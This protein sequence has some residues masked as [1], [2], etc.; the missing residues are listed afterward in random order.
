MS[1][2]KRITVDERAWREIQA[3]AARLRDVQRELPSMLEAVRR[4]QQEQASRDGA[5][6]RARQDELTRSLASL[7]DQA[8]RLEASTS[9]RL[10]AATEM[11]LNEVRESAGQVR[12][13]T[14]QLLDQQQRRFTAE[15]AQEREERRQEFGALREQLTELRADRERAAAAAATVVADAQHLRDAIAGTLPHERFAPGRLAALGKRLALAEDN[16][17][18]GHGEAALAQAQDLYLQLGE[19]RVEVELKNAEWL[20]ARLTGISAVTAL[21]EQIRYNTRLDVTDEG[22]TAELDVDFWS[23]GELSAI[24]AEADALAA[25]VNDEAD[26][27]ALDELRAIAEHDVAALNER[28]TETVTTARARQLASQIRVNLAEMVVGVLEQTTGYAWDGEATYAGEDQRGA[29]YSKLRHPDDSEIV[30][31]VAPDD[32]GKSCVLRI[33]SFETGLPDDSER[34]RRAHAIADSLREQGLQTGDPS[35][36]EEF[37]DQKFTD[38]EQLRRIQR[39]V[40]ERG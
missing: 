19:L 9:R 15:L 27:P 35:A 12:A 34:V 30:V 4:A 22:V 39:T 14:G 7:S 23:D 17:A 40:P 10:K 25:R 5:Q 3:K 8:K 21:T 6:M 11:I 20:A 38:F 13:E 37:P 33:L 26:P 36:E 1:G 31:E 29:F 2:T 16:I 24:S 32:D 28:L 18:Q